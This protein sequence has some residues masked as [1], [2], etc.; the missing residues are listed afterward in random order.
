MI[1][2][3]YLVQRED[4]S[5]LLEF[6]GDNGIFSISIEKNVKESGWYYASL[7]HKT[8]Y[9]DL[10]EEMMECLTKFFEENNT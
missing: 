2:K 1:G 3:P 4:G 5:F 7:N 8:Q 9:G 6:S 10:T